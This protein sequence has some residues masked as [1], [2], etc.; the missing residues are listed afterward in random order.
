GGAGGAGASDAGLADGAAAA[1]AGGGGGASGDDGLH[2]VLSGF[3][4]EDGEPER[5][6]FDSSEPIV[7]T[8]VT[9]FVVSHKDLSAIT[10]AAGQTAGHYVTV[11]PPF[12]YWDNATIRYEGGADLEDQAGQ[13]LLPFAIHHV[14]NRLT[15]AEGTAQEIFVSASVATSGNGETEAQAFKT[16][17]EG[18]AAMISGGGNKIWVK[19]GSYGSEVLTLPRS[20]TAERP[21]SIEGYRDSPGDITSLYYAYGDGALDAAE[22][23]LFDGGDRGGPTFMDVGSQSHWI[24]RNLQ[25]TNY[26]IGIKSVS[27]T[28]GVIANTVV[29]DLGAYGSDGGVGIHLDSATNAIRG[30]RILDSVI[31]NA[32]SRGLNVYGSGNLV[33]GNR[34]YC[35]EAPGGPGDVAGTTDYY[36]H[37][38][39][40]DNVVLD[41]LVHKDTPNGDGHLGHGITLKAGDQPSEYNLVEGCT[42]IGIYGAFQ[43]RHPPCRYNVFR[44]C[45][46]HADIPNRRSSDEGTGGIEFLAGGEGNLFDGIYVHDTDVAINFTDNSESTSAVIASG[47]L[48]RNSVF[49]DVKSVIRSSNVNGWDTHVSDNRVYNCTFFGAD[50][51]FR[52]RQSTILFSGN[53]L[54]NCI[55]Q[56][57]ATL[58]TPTLEPSSGWSFDTNSFVGGLPVQGSSALAVDPLLVDPAAGDFHLQ[59]GSPVENAGRDLSE[60]R[61]DREG[62]ERRAGMS[63]LGA[64]EAD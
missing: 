30:A 37:V 41:N 23:P 35:N 18:L 14:D 2:P 40:T 27:F 52:I 39:G 11:A 24:V 42:A 59:A 58:D 32:T 54:S 45:E 46:S 6:Y 60:V 16:L 44:R 51:L 4:V 38:R 3:R 13:E 63:S 33:R 50:Y 26:R 47:N 19:A 15:I 12:E 56:N 7:G 31:I 57:V 61:Y 1:D 9:G 64:H 49:A 53:E 21:N 34:V 48:I 20:G 5:I 62:V 25:I 17:Q 43:V 36:I 10:I 29:K 8:S 55:F 28:G 22:M